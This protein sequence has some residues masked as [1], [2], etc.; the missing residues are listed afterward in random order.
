VYLALEEEKK[1]PLKNINAKGTTKRA[2]AE[3]TEPKV[4]NIPLERCK[5][6]EWDVQRTP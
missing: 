2:L 5:A 3:I 4:N 6:I 1:D